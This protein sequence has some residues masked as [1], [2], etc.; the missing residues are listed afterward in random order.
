[1]E[2]TAIEDRI[3]VSMNEDMTGWLAERNQTAGI[4]WEALT[5]QPNNDRSSNKSAEV[6]KECRKVKGS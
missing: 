1:M 3:E 2:E 5:L 6:C 4:A